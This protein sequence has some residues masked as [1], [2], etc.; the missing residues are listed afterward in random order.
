MFSLA[1]KFN[2]RRNTNWFCWILTPNMVI[3]NKFTSEA[4]R[5]I[6]CG[7]IFFRTWGMES[8]KLLIFKP[9]T[10]WTRRA[11]FAAYANRGP[12]TRRAGFPAFAMVCQKPEEHLNSKP[13]HVR[14]IIKW[15]V[16]TGRYQATPRSQ[17]ERSQVESSSLFSF[18][19]IC[20]LLTGFCTRYTNLRKNMAQILSVCEDTDTPFMLWTM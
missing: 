2:L 6:N 17:V 10:L 9:L 19:T 3:L 1:F 16:Y 18:R 7:F 12:K 11:G 13:A 20:N 8:I 15:F 4:V 14:L 5:S